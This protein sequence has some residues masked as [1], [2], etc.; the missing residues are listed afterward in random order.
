MNNKIKFGTDGYRGIINKTFTEDTVKTIT[1]A[2]AQ[3]LGSG[4]III[5]YDGRYNADKYA[6]QSAKILANFG[7]EV[8]LSSRVVPTPVIAYTACITENSSGAIMFTASHNPKEYMGIK[9][10][11]NYGGPAT[12][13]ITRKIETLIEENIFTLEE[14][15]GS[16]LKKDFSFAYFSAIEKLIDF[17]AIKSNPPKI[18]YDGLFSASIGYFDEIL[19]RNNIDFEIYNNKY[20]PDFGGFLPEPV[21]KNLKHTKSGFI[22]LANDGDAD[23]YGVIDEEGNYVSPNIIM[24]ILL[25]YLKN[26]GEEGAVVK[27]TGVSQIVDNVA[28]KLNIPVIEVPVGFKWIGEK[29]RMNKTILGGEDSGGLSTGRHISEKDGIYANLLILEAV[30][31]TGKT[32]ANLSREIEYFAGTKFY[33][34]R[35]DVRLDSDEKKEEL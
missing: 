9:F 7:F 5:G 32:L 20:D 28:A 13:E 24:A 34:D 30:A 2:I 8:L 18:I 29:M 6:E 1:L 4:K 31:K 12:S 35:V 26:K 19:K 11:P 14:K 21:F 25:K 10:I 17:E 22:T 15:D 16:I 23:R 3:Y 27:T 33:Q